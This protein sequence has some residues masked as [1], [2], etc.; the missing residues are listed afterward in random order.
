MN[1]LLDGTTLALKIV[2]SSVF[3]VAEILAIEDHRLDSTFLYV[4]FGL[5]SLLK[6]TSER[7][8]SDTN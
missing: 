5:Q 4:V 7:T 1:N 2:A 8:S 6:P 3:P